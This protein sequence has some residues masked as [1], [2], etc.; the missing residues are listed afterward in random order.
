MLEAIFRDL[1]GNPFQPTAFASRWRTVDV[2]G[3]AQAIYEDNAFG[4]L[5]ILAD[6]LMDAGCWDESII[7]HC[8]SR[9]PHARG[10]WLVDLILDRS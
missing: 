2:L 10:C 4:R 7:G 9:G 3:V 6:A 1:V 5:P 8:R